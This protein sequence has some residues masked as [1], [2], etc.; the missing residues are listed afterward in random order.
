MRDGREA[1]QR[2]LTAGM[3]A[4]LV[5]AFADVSQATTPDGDLKF[6]KAVCHGLARAIVC[7]AYA[8]PIYQLCH[9]VNLADGC[10]RGNERF[11]WL[12]FAGSR[13]NARHFR[14][15]LGDVVQSRGWR[16]P[17]FSL[18]DNG[19]A[20]AYADGVFNVPFTR[21]PLLAAMFE[22]L[23]STVP[24]AA[25][26]DTFS[27]IFADASC[28]TAIGRAANTLQRHLYAY[29]SDHLS[30]AQ[31][32]DKFTAI[33]EF[34]EERSDGA[35]IEVDDDAVLAFWRRASG[36]TDGSGDF[37]GY[38]TVF[39]GFV[40]LMRSLDVAETR[41][42]VEHADPIGV[43]AESGEIDVAAIE[44]LI[45]QS[46]EWYSPLGILDAGPASRI[47]MLNLAELGY[48]TQL[49]ACG[50]MSA[51]LPISLMRSECFCAAQA[52]IT[53][54]LRR[55]LAGDKFQDLLDCDDAETYDDRK[56]GYG[57]VRGHID[58]V[59]KA[60][61]YVTMRDHQVTT[62]ANVVA[63]HQNTRGE[64]MD[65]VMDRDIEVS[66]RDLGEALNEAKR[67]FAKISRRGFED[68]FL[69]DPEI[70]EGFALGAGALMA[71]DELISSFAGHLDNLDRDSGLA[72]RFA[73]DTEIFRA[74]FA[75]LYGDRVWARN[76]KCQQAMHGHWRRGCSPQSDRSTP[77]R[78]PVTTAAA[79]SASNGSTPTRWI[80]I[81][82]TR[83]SSTSCEP[84]P[85]SAR[86]SS[87]SSTA[88]RSTGCRGLPP[89]APV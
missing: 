89:R 44:P 25:V 43:D 32:Q 81:A 14:S 63:L 30:S 13:L 40:D 58:R 24:Y 5:N 6:Q 56:Q 60:A 47:K 72:G 33:I 53:Q 76:T 61:A 86:H 67:V 26:D 66:D 71:I 54:G 87:A 41:L 2:I 80:R 8:N 45:A 62:G 48:V 57:A 27:E 70:V 77:Y 84:I 73:A 74:Q 11:E 20:I 21:M 64:L 50:P 35:T 34:L 1:R 85:T 31:E 19:V 36:Q 37:R 79:G 28:Q 46:G 82:R 65:E 39:E 16:R 51:R 3:S 68:E 9:L 78:V 29:L 18:S 75:E 22:F 15:T 4:D 38:R 23:V 52:R 42:A 55:K 88:R 69:D 10:G 12:F 83:S 49:C 17:G 59:L 7:R